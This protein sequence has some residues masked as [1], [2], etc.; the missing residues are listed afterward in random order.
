MKLLSIDLGKRTSVTCK[1]INGVKP[2]YGKV[3]TTPAAI[4]ECEVK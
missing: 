1:Y 4:D 3:H 2:K